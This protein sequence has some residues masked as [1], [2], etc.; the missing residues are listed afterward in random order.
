VDSRPPS[1]LLE[2]LAF[3]V[4][5]SLTATGLCLAVDSIWFPD[6][7]EELQGMLPLFPPMVALPAIIFSCLGMAWVS[8]SVEAFGWCLIVLCSALAQ[9]PLTRLVA[10]L[11]E[12][13]FNPLPV[14][15]ALTLAGL[16][17]RLLPRHQPLPTH[18]IS[19]TPAPAPA[20]APS[21]TQAASSALPLPHEPSPASTPEKPRLR[22]PTLPSEEAL[23]RQSGSPLSHWSGKRGRS[24]LRSLAALQAPSPTSTP[25]PAPVSSNE[26]VAAAAE[27]SCSK[28]TFAT[29]LHC[30]ILNHTQ[31]AHA[32]PSTEYTSLL[33]RWLAICAETCEA[34]G[35]EIERFGTHSFRAFFADSPTHQPHAPSAIYCALTLRTRLL[36]LSEE[37]EIRCGCELDAHLGINSGD[38]LL[39]NLGP[40]DR[41]QL[42]LAGEAAEWATR[43]ATASR[44]YGCRI[45]VGAQTQRLADRAAEFR[46]IDLLQRALP[47]EP[48][49]EVHE[50]LALPGSLTA[51]TKQRLRH[52]REGFAHFRARRWSA[53]RAAL[54]SALP[55]A[56]LDEPAVLMLRKIDEQ[57]ALAG[58]A[59]DGH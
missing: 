41:R 54:R 32:L 36:A 4:L 28:E 11:F 37:C 8:L 22:P 53:A 10:T 50:L 3:S 19:S 1:H 20:S 58:L 26:T 30:E 7:P 29:V 23:S 33:N 47:P 35:G 45:L 52:Y 34:R 40:L 25:A 55:E 57:E 12:R 18:G 56:G 14:A 2:R 16:L 44:T 5:C 59:L 31:L 51:E 21:P 48:P 39:A 43:L 38:I 15:C 49:E 42:S 6:S 17:P 13:E 24:S 27:D 9:L 46:P